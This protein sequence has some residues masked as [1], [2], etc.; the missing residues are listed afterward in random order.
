MLFD[1]DEPS[2]YVLVKDGDTGPGLDVHGPLSMPVAELLIEIVE[3]EDPQADLTID[4]SQTTFPDARAV[5]YLIGELGCR[6]GGP[7]IRVQGSC[8]RLL[9]L[10]PRVQLVPATQTARRD[11]ARIADVSLDA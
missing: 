3:H 1:N 8:V 5:R 9:R 10:H 11:R 2:A 7:R 6:L 4:L